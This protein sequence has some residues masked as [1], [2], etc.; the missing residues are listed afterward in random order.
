MLIL[1]VYS[2]TDPIKKHRTED[3]LETKMS[4][5]PKTFKIYDLDVGVSGISLDPGEG[6]SHRF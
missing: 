2:T 6:V 5:G 4:I 1:V 3:T